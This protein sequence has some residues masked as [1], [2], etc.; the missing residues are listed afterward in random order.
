MLLLSSSSFVHPNLGTILLL[1]IHRK[2]ATGIE[3]E[4]M[5]CIIFF[6]SVVFLNYMLNG[7]QENKC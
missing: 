3:Q 6:K 1:S 4:E 7:D 5:L 2:Q